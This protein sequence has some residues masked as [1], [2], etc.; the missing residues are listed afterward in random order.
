M[1]LAHVSLG[2]GSVGWRVSGRARDPGV[3]CWWSVGSALDRV[4]YL[5]V[6]LLVF[7]LLVVLDHRGAG[8]RLPRLGRIVCVP[9]LRRLI[10]GGLSG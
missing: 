2:Y 6:S 5:V 10:R 8:L 7:P 4:R 9:N 1:S 3:G